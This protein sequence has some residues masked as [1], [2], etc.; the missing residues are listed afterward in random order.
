VQQL[1]PAADGRLS[2]LDDT[3]LAEAYAVPAGR[4][5]HLRMNFVTSADGG[6][7]VAGLSAGLS[8][9]ADKRL[10]TLLRDL[11]DVVLV[12]AGTV[13]AEGYR[14]QRYGPERRRRRVQLGGSELPVIAVVS[15]ALD[16]D[17]TSTLF[18][19]AEAT[20]RTIV[21]TCRAAPADRL[22]ALAEV[23]D[24]LVAGDE[25]VGLAAALGG[26]VERGLT[27]VLCEGGPTLFG[28][29]LRAGLVDELC[30]TVSP[31]LTGPGAGRIVAGQPLDIGPGPL[32]LLHLLEE[33]GVLLLRYAVPRDRVLSRDSSH[34]REE[35]P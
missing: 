1:L 3:G 25:R 35:S 31:L 20:A 5:S 22:A 18:T 9:P 27:R 6:V 17:P 28:G 11:A 21:I 13:R 10:F 4:P 30:L 34:R 15:G 2:D 7:T 19:K 29:L 8:S 23:A 12:G 33:D 14:A 24:V 32:R 26:L 16:L